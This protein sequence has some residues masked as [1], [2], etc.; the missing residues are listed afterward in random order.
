MCKWFARLCA[1]FAVLN[2]KPKIMKRNEQRFIKEVTRKMNKAGFK[3]ILKDDVFAIEKD[4]LLLQVEMCDIPGWGRRRVRFMLN[5]AF[6]EMDKVKQ[7]GLLS[8][9]SECNN[10]NEYTTTQ[11]FQDHF[12]C[13]IETFVSSAKDF[14]REFEFA[15]KELGETYESLA[16]NYPR[17]RE[18]YKEQP[19]RRP[20]GYL[21]SINN[22]DFTEKSNACNKVAQSSCNFVCGK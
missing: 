22:D 17:F 11:F 12:T 7:A 3:C 21:A 10:H 6:E 8:L 4:E 15:S 2:I 19:V 14:V 16:N 13:R 5:F 20:I 18:V 9:T 1:S